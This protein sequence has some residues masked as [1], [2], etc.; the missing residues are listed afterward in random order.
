MQA[1]AAET[2]PRFDTGYWSD[3]S[4]AGDPA[5]VSYQEYVTQLLHKLAP[6]D[7]R[8]AAAAIRFTS[9]LTQPPAFKLVERAGRLRRASGCPSRR[10]STRSR[11]PARRARCRSTPA[12]TP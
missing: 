3:Y 7:P 12:G 1:A 6:A 5:P 4:L 10:T 9:Y 11:R 2:L 8:F